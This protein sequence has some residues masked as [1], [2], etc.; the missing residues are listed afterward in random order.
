VPL[1]H[2]SQA[3]RLPHLTEAWINI[4]KRA[5]RGRGQK[6]FVIQIAHHVNQ[7]RGVSNTL[8]HLGPR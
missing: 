4:Q 8:Q 3:E 1:E 7:N 6:L 5:P 2:L